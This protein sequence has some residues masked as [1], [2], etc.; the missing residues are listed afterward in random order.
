MDFKIAGTGT[1]ITALQADIKLPGITMD[2]VSE[3]IYRA[4]DAKKHILDIM[5]STI[6]VAR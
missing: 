4:H 6:P 2:V 3:A 5:K 1:G